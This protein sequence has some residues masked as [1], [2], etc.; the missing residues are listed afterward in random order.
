MSD[1]QRDLQVVLDSSKENYFHGSFEVWKKNGIIAYVP[2]ETVLKEM[3]T[4]IE[5]VKPALFFL[6]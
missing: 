6:I 5:K 3:A 4:K 1:I 2:K